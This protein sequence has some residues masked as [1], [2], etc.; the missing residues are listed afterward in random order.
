MSVLS[1]TES[2]TVGILKQPKVV[3]FEINDQL[4]P[5]RSTDSIYQWVTSEDWKQ[6]KDVLSVV[7]GSSEELWVWNEKKSEDQPRNVYEP[8]KNG[9]T[10]TCFRWNVPVF[11]RTI[12]FRG[13]VE[14]SGDYVTFDSLKMELT[15]KPGYLLRY[16]C[17]A[18]FHE[19]VVFNEK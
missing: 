5:V 4:V 18:N 2:I 15:A 12:C 16:N 9:K 8:Y 19:I 13:H 6:N 14:I 1:R 7:G 10:I 3:L 11:G 17:A